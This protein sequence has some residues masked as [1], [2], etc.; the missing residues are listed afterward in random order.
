[1]TKIVIGESTQK[2]AGELTF[3]P[4][5][6]NIIYALPEAQIKLYTSVM[7]YY[8]EYWY[9]TVCRADNVTIFM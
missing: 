4:C 1:L 5:K 3:M 9:K 2:L 6:C 8:T 7:P